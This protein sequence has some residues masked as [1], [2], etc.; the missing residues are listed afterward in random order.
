MKKS[1]RAFSGLLFITLSALLI[2]ASP[3]A[4]T[5]DEIIKP[6]EAEVDNRTIQMLLEREGIKG[7]GAEEIPRPNGRTDRV[8]F[9]V[10]TPEEERNTRQEERE[11]MERALEILKN[12]T[13]EHRRR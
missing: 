12:M 3:Q 10:T 13:I 2:S 11:K 9:S 7:E 4:L 1:S 8:Y 5:V 6:K